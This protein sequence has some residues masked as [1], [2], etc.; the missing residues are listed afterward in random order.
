RQRELFEAVVR[1]GQ[2]TA[3]R[4]PVNGLRPSLWPSR[5]KQGETL[6]RIQ[7]RQRAGQLH[8]VLSDAA[9]PVICQPSVEGNV[10]ASRYSSSSPFSA[11]VIEGSPSFRRRVGVLSQ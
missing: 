7:R 6:R 8:A 3:G 5:A 4:Q 11:P 9:R 10:C 2:Q 1:R